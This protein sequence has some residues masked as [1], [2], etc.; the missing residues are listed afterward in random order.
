MSLLESREQRYI[1]AI[2]NNITMIAVSS[3]DIVRP[4]AMMLQGGNCVELLVKFVITELFSSYQKPW[5]M[6]DRLGTL[7][8][9]SY[10]IIIICADF[11][12]YNNR[13]DTRYV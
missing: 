2:N 6:S 5:K 7:L 4:K 8:K 3:K 10:P 11:T 9:P 12:G 13:S 1:K